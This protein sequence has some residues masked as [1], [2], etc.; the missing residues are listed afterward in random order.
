VPE[1]QGDTSLTGSA[2]PPTEMRL[3]LAGAAD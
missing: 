3:A 1:H 2:S